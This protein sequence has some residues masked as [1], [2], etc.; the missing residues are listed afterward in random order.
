MERKWEDLL[1]TDETERVDIDAVCAMLAAS[2]WA[3]DRDRGTIEASV[4][5]SLCLS[6]YADGRQV[7]FLR[8]VTDRATFAWIC[9]VVVDEAHRGRSI[10]KRLMETA[11]EHPAIRGTNMGLAT[12]DAHTLYEKYGFVRREAMARTKNQTAVI[13]RSGL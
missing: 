11:L 10:G 12:R 8:A 13:G 2:Y 3:A 7:G 1:I 6:A 4:R 5:G 9:D